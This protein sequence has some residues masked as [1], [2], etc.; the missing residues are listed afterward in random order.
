MIGTV[1]VYW[2]PGCPF[3]RR[4][5]GA[6]HR[7][8]LPFD[9]INI[10]A[11]PAAAA[12]L[13]SIAGGT[14]T[15]PTVVV[16]DRRLVNP[17]ARQVFDAVRAQAPELLDGIDQDAAPHTATAR[18]WATAPLVS[19]VLAMGWVLLAAAHPGTTY[20]F[21]PLVVAAACPVVTRWQAGSALSVRVGCLVAGF[22]GAAAGTATA[23][24]A[25]AGDLNGPTLTGSAHA[26]TE[27]VVSL[28]IGVA[29]GA[30]IAWTRHVRHDQGR[31][32][33][34]GPSHDDP[35][36]PQSRRT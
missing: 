9:E 32:S 35:T 24:L 33:P 13:R 10:W 5:L 23:V 15:V 18:R 29:A 22:G 1:Q 2:R 26:V 20:H 34:A 4:L 7:S 17:T 31:R 8:G 21:A 11:D 14:E 3:C 27:T 25:A 16:E 6:L 19:V 28:L 36:T 30:A 12:T